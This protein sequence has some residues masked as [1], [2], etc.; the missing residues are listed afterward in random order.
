MARSGCTTGSPGQD[1][2]LAAVRALTAD[3]AAL[4]RAAREPLTAAALIYAM[5]LLHFRYR[6]W[7][8]QEGSLSIR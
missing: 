7:P 6:E 4:R 3:V 8:G 5:L 2:L 1:R